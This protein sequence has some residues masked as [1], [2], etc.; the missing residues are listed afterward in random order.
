MSGA[1]L[2]GGGVVG[3]PVLVNGTLAPGNSPG[4]LTVSNDVMVAGPA[5]LQYELGTSSDL[6]VVSGN[7]TLGGILNV[8][9][10]G[11]FGNN[12]YTLFTYSGALSY[13]GLSIGGVP[14]GHNYAISTNTPGQVNLV[15]TP[16]LTAFTSLPRCGR[17]PTW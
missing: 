10:A 13:S 8:T 12:T 6:T 2:G 1:A 4:M 16:P 5:V 3:G 15:V 7:L 14:L 9:D 17:A 11:G